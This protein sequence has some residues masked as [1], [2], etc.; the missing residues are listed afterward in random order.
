MAAQ[1]ATVLATAHARAHDNF[2]KKPTLY[3][4]ADE[5]A[6]L[7]KGKQS[8]FRKQVK[9]VAFNY[10]DQVAKD[11]KAFKAALGPKDCPPPE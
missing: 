9:E 3:P 2:R 1:Y 6:D 4:L 8:A 11:Y 10:A 7:V 5:V